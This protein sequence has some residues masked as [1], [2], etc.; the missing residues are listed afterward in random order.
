MGESGA[1]NARLLGAVQD[2]R[3]A[4]SEVTLPLDLPG[5]ASGRST[6]SRL[7]DQLDDYVIPRLTSID[8]PLLAVVGGST[9]A[10]KSTLVNSV[11]GGEVSLSGVL[12]PTTRSPV[13]V[14]HP[15]DGAWF[16]GQRILPGLARITGRHSSSDGPGAVRLVSSESV[17]AGLALLDAPD[18]D[19]VVE[20]NRELAGQLLAAADLWIFVTTAARYADAVPWDLLREASERGT[21]VAVVLDRVPAPAVDEI[22]THLASM[23]REQ[24][25]E[26]APIFTVLESELVDGLLPD[27]QVERLRAWLTAL[28]GDAQARAVVVRQTLEGALTSLDARTRSLLAAGADQAAAGNALVEAARTAYAD[29]T[30]QVHEGMEDGSLLRGEVLARWQEFVGTG[31]FFRQVESTVSRVRDRFTSFIKGEPARADNLGEALQSGVEALISNRGELAASATARAWRVLPGGDQLLAA[32]PGLARSSDAAAAKAER[33][34]RDWQGDILEMVRSE[35]RD[36]RTTARI[37]AYGVN[38]LGVVLMLVTFASTAGV[39]GA[40]IGI[41]GGTA[42][43]GQKLLE[44]VFGDQAVRELARQ[45]RE[46]LLTRVEELYAAERERYEGAVTTVHVDAEKTAHL[47]KAAA[48]VRAAR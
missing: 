2:L 29:A 21:A 8:A 13:L 24:G 45:A 9:G 7:L 27:D 35:G 18:I 15:S 47:E 23:L 36:R 42:V 28:A 22:R 46:R 16:S 48:A 41:A 39:T 38:G 19:S 25:L 30:T 34:V 32:D 3:S 10:G 40:E 37:M 31:E 4:V 43:V 44:A 20:A 26:Q 5:A 14:H 1:G 6:R 11:V 12:R 33:V 17:A